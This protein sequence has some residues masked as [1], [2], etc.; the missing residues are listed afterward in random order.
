MT[1]S[2]TCLTDQEKEQPTKPDKQD[3]GR[4]PKLETMG[5]LMR[6]RLTNATEKAREAGAAQV[7]EETDD[8][9]QKIWV[10]K[11]LPIAA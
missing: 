1:S 5:D 4:G 9:G 8:Q 11:F 10:V 7:S 2:D 6:L 3:K